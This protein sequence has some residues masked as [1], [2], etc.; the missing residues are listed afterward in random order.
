M[1]EFE[2]SLEKGKSEALLQDKKLLCGSGESLDVRCNEE[3]KNIG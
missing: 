1:L 3:T 2:S